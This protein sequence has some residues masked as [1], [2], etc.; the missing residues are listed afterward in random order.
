MKKQFKRYISRSLVVVFLSNIL[1]VPDTKAMTVP[2]PAVMAFVM[3]A[4]EALVNIVGH[5]S[6]LE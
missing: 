1:I 6:I 5:F 2:A 4:V 3:P